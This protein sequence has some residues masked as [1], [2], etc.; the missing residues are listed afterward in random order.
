VKDKGLQHVSE[1]FVVQRLFCGI[2]PALI[3]IAFSV[4][5]SGCITT[6]PSPLKPDPKTAVA[7]RTALAG[8]YIR[9]GDLDAAQRSLEMALNIDPRSAEANNMM[10]VLL[11][12]EGSPSNLV[13]AETY[14]KRAISID[15]EFA[16]ARNNY[17]V[18]LNGRKRYPE[19]VEQFKVAGSSLGYEGRASA[20]ENLGRTYLS[21]NDSKNAEQAFKQA[22]QANRDSVIARLE[23]AEIFLA[24]EQVQDASSLYNDYLRSLGSQNQGARSLWL[25]IR[26]ARAER[27]TFRM[28]TFINQLGTDYPS[29]AE[30]Q[31]YLQLQKNPEAVWK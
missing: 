10:G 27:D 11:Q 15:S 29:S 2:A 25:G 6:G 13:K 20:L 26:I 17:G 30:Y 23:L 7:T 31:R 18:F 14:F 8:Q 16:Q 5:L 9:S 1:V 3:A 24:R 22:L 4:T 28:K 19:A 21:L 12:Q